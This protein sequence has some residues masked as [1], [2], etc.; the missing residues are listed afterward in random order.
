[1]LHF[2]VQTGV[3]NSE[4]GN[5]RETLLF[6]ADACINLSHAPISLLLY[7]LASNHAPFP[8]DKVKGRIFFERK[9]GL[10]EEMYDNFSF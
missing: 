3:G 4:G 9:N 10:L 5:N 7:H 8:D 6:V 2:K 1:M